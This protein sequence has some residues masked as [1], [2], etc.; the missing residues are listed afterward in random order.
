M[1]QA[2]MELKIERI[3]RTKESM[4]KNEL[5]LKQRREELSRKELV[6]TKKCEEEVAKRNK[7]N[8]ARADLEIKQFEQGEK[9]YFVV[10][11]M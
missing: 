7:I 1:F 2:E 5:L 8:A 4:E 9:M 10:V 3:K 11:M 6:E